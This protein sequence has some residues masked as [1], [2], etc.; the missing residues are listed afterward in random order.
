MLRA[1]LPVWQ[2]N[3][4]SPLPKTKERDCVW[5][6]LGDTWGVWDSPGHVRWPACPEAFATKL[7]Y[8]SKD[9]AW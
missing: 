1:A 9:Q 4:G 2:G 3:G 7:N 8:S 5:V 6:A